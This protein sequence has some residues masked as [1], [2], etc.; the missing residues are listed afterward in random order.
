MYSDQGLGAWLGGGSDGS[1]SGSR[2]ERVA[3]WAVNWTF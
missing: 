2:V 1:A 3:N